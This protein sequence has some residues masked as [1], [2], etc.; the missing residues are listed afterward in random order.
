LG[1]S[2]ADAKQMTSDQS[3]RG[4]RKAAAASAGGAGAGEP[5]SHDVLHALTIGTATAVGDDF[6]RALARHVAL[7][8]GYRFA[9]VSELHADTPEKAR[10][11]AIWDTDRFTEPFDFDLTGTPCEE[12]ARGAA[13][14]FPAGV[15]E[16]FPRD[17]WLTQVGAQ[18][19][20]GMPVLNAKGTAVGLITAVHTEPKERDNT[21]WTALA[22]FAARAAAELERKRAEHALRESEGRFRMIYEHSPVMMHSVDQDGRICNVNSKWLEATGYARDEVVG[23]T[24]F[25][26]LDVSFHDS[27][28]QELIPRFW[29]DGRLQATP[30]QIICQ[31]GD[32]MDILMDCQMVTEPDG[33]R[34]GLSVVR[35]V[36]EQRRAQE[37]QQ[38]LLA[39]IEQAAEIILITDT[40]GTILYVNPAFETTTGFTRDEALGA[41]PAIQ[42]SGKHDAAFYRNLWA[43]ITAG[44]TWS[45]RFIN[46]KKDGSLYEEEATISPVRDAGGRIV[47]Y[48]AVKRD[49]T[50]EAA[51]ES[52]LRQAQKME[53]IGQLAGGV[54]H[55]FNN[56]LQAMM[57]HA[58]LG[59]DSLAPD[60]PAYHDL[61][62]I[63][64]TAVRAAA[65][66]RQLLA[67]S[68]RQV[69]QSKNVYLNDVIEHILQMI[70]RVIGS[71]IRLAFTPDP[72]LGAVHADPHQIEQVLMNLC[73]NARDAMPDGGVIDIATCHALVD[74]RFQEAH[75][76]ARPGRYVVMTVT[77]TGVGMKPDTVARVFE[78]FF[79]T[80][81]VGQGTGL[82]LATVYGIIKQHNGLVHVYSEPGKG[83]TFK[84]YLPRVDSVGPSSPAAPPAATTTTTRGH[85]LILLA[86]DEE[87]VRNGTIRVLE[88][89]GY[90]VLGAKNGTE[91]LQMFHAHADDIAF[92]LLDVTMPEI[93]G[94]EVARHLRRHRPEIPVLFCS[95]YGAAG[96]TPQHGAH[97]HQLLQKPFAPAD[98]LKKIRQLLDTKPTQPH[99][100]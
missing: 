88:N 27:V 37:G 46:R 76:W 80:K 90:R 48:V 24:I 56:L 99:E 38:R 4:K 44:D 62:F 29:R 84:I 19:Y 23:R 79:T 49:I 83:S 72:D 31:D 35:N 32:A 45:G 60:A 50:R 67:F 70:S 75:P 66:T 92:A 74:A 6:I 53:A 28:R 42:Q 12:S 43:T 71:H 87:M 91:A 58:A 96:T 15:A 77:D 9:M 95:G 73:V 34:V 13:C 11:L 8:F 21:V 14:F 17:A 93:G 2:K 41:R 22:I 94:V 52:Q 63:R 47:N 55:D 26:F 5:G 16:R 30:L 85:E 68:R 39:A 78:P 51:L 59:M 54:A 69:L 97:P 33:R 18:S 82:G 25:T 36:T 3:A 1:R 81:E 86:E 57:A 64:D 65:L 98:L 7:V 61:V 40:E 89:A 100:E 10:V 20:L